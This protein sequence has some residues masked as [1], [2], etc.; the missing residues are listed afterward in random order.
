MYHYRFTRKNG[1]KNMHASSKA[2][3]YDSR[4]RVVTTVYLDVQYLPEYIS[5]GTKRVRDAN[6][7]AIV[8]FPWPQI[9][10]RYHPINE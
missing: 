10:K 6:Q 5:I 1:G 9:K 4:L 8:D 7:N 3:E 2:G